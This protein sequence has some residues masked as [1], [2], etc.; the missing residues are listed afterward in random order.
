MRLTQGFTRALN[1][2]LFSLAPDRDCPFHSV[3][4]LVSV[5]LILVL[6]QTDVIRYLSLEVSR[7]SSIYTYNIQQFFNYPRLH[8]IFFINKIKFIML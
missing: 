3:S 4:R 7:L 5:A 2:L 1:T 6:L 8:T